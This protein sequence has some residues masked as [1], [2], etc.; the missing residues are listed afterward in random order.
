MSQENINI[1][2]ALHTAFSS[3]DAE[4]ATNLVSDNFE[5]KIVPFGMTLGGCEGFRQGFAAFA[6]P[7]P[8]ARFDYKNVL[9]NGD[10][11]VIEYDFV[12]TQTGALMTPAGPIAPTGRPI[13]LPGIELY[14][15]QDHKIV[16]LHTYFDSATMLT[17][18]GAMPQ[19]V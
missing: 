1:V 9:D 4:A 5:W 2:R 10:Q 11:V 14:Q 8:G 6:D 17:Q 3:R 16:S 12:G 19:A 18:L 15:L 7:F 13:H